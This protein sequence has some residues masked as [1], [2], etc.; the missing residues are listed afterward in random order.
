MATSK[1]SLALDPSLAGA[2][3]RAALVWGLGMP[4]CPRTLAVPDYLEELLARVRAA[5]DAFL[6]P[7]RKAAV[8]DMLRYGTYKPAGRSKPSSEYLLA[9]ALDGSFPLVNGPVD[10]NNAVSLEW[11]YPASVFD[12]AKTGGELFLRRGEPGEAYVFNPSGQEIDLRDLLVA[13]RRS[14]GGM[15]PGM[16]PGW[17]PGWEPCGNPVKDAMA[18]KVFDEARD[19]VAIVYAPIA[20]P[21]QRLESCASRFALLLRE[22]CGAGEAGFSIVCASRA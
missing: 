14:V 2:P 16:E 10:A 18:T 6:E 19:A 11:G 12:L 8:R 1:P 13:C 5:G 15:E 21:A 3:L 4:S 7:E 20:D 9:A 22:R 17:E